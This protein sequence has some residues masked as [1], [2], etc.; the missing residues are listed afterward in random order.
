MF[1]FLP[2]LL[3]KCHLEWI[4]KICWWKPFLIPSKLTWFLLDCW[5]SFNAF[6]AKSLSLN[7]CCPSFSSL[8]LSLKLPLI[9]LFLGRCFNITL[10]WKENHHLN[11]HI[12]QNLC[13]P[14]ACY[15]SA[16]GNLSF[17]QPPNCSLPCIFTHRLNDC[18]HSTWLAGSGAG[19]QSRETW[20]QTPVLNH[21]TVLLHTYATAFFL[22]LSPKYLDHLCF[23]IQSLPFLSNP[24]QFLL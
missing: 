7:N 11:W 13:S 17:P 12:L 4:T 14:C 18:P 16:N 24:L 2:L 15:S 5:W 23:S 8:P 21:N 1:C 22:P 6:L 20:L 9:F 19:L 10:N 3:H